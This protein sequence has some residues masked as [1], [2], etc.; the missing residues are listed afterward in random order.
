MSFEKNITTVAGVLISNIARHY[1]TQMC[2]QESEYNNCYDER[3]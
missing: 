3:L 1:S 2:A